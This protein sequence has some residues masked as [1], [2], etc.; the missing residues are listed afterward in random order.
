MA[1]SSGGGLREMSAGSAMRG[2]VPASRCSS[3]HWL[4][5]SLHRLVESQTH[6]AARGRLEQEVAAQGAAVRDA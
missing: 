4:L 2:D 5:F 6:A 3:S 1:G